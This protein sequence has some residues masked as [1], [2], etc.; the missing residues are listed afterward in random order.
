MSNQSLFG[1]DVS[2]HQGAIDWSLVSNAGVNYVFI[3]AT[4]GAT[5]VDPKFK[6]NWEQAKQFNIRR[7]AYHFFRPH[8]PVEKQA[9]NLIKTVGNLEKG[10]IPPVLDIEE[11][12]RWTSF[13]LSKRINLIS[14]WLNMVEDGLGIKPIIYLSP[15]FAKDILDNHS[16]LSAYLLWIA[17]YT[18]QKSP[19][20]PSP[21]SNWTFW[22]Y[23]DSGTVNGIISNVVDLNRFNGSNQELKQILVQV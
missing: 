18:N 10:D 4:E 22:Q 19:R 14:S 11:P 2:R 21:W 13:S 12:H 23:S 16:T 3:K 6:Y 20:V 17:H 5:W 7:G 8:S 15:S 1:I 9:N